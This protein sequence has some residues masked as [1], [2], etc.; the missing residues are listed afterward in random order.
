M[1]ADTDRT[2]PE[3]PVTQ[4]FGQ[5]VVEGSARFWAAHF[6]EPDHQFAVRAALCFAHLMDQLTFVSPEV[7]AEKSVWWHEE[8]TNRE[9]GTAR[10][11]VTQCL[12]ATGTAGGSEEMQRTEAI[13]SA[14]HRH[15]HGAL[16]SQ[17]QTPL[18]TPELWHQYA[19][20]RFGTLHELIALASGAGAEQAT[21]IVDWS[22][23]LHGLGVMRAPECYTD[24]RVLVPSTALVEGANDSLRQSLDKL[25]NSRPAASAANHVLIDHELR[26]WKRDASDASP[27]FT[28]LPVGLRGMLASWRAARKAKHNR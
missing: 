26:W 15:L 24:S 21:D 14:M 17:Q 25:R 18:D 1:N 8:L 2:R 7:I 11:P 27:I 5:S 23:Q 28:G 3:V 9:A 10:H 19:Q 16:M 4:L 20:L 12:L 13:I 6:T 22:A